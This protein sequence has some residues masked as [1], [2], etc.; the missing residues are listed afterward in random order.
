MIEQ[1]HTDIAIDQVKQQIRELHRSGFELGLH[2]HPQWYNAKYT[3]GSWM[4]DYNEYNLCTLPRERIIQIIDRSVAYFQKILKDPGFIPI[5]FRAGNWLF[6][7]TQI[8]ADVLS[9][10]GIRID[11][12]VFKGG[13]QYQH[14]LDY[15]KSLINGNYWKFADDVNIPDDRGI[16]LELP[17]YTQ[18]VPFWKML[19][20]KRVGLQRKVTSSAQNSKKSLT[21]YLDFI[22]FLYPLKLDFCRMTLDELISMM[23]KIIKKQRQNTSS[24]LP[25][26]SIGHT[27]DLMDFETVNSF[28]NYLEENKVDISTFEGV[29]HKLESVDKAECR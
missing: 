17:I 7:P 15:R 22:R 21:R 10:K 14:N 12:S 6:Q 8:A 23:E 29:F 1:Y 25:I 5:S 11:S 28:L 16:M 24:Y 2:L 20:G 4:L 18:M 26:V 9:E 13:R 19:T 3:Y 27:K